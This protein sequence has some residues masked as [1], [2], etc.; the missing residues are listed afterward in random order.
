VQKPKADAQTVGLIVLG[1]IVLGLV[2]FLIIGNIQGDSTDHWNNEKRWHP[3]NTP[4]P[5]FPTATDK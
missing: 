1:V 2:A 5:S 4:A 3:T